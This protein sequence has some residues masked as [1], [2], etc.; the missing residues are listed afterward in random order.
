MSNNTYLIRF[1]SFDVIPS[2]SGC[3][4]RTVV[5][6]DSTLNVKTSAYCD[7]GADVK[8]VKPNRTTYWSSTSMVDLW[9]YSGL[10]TPA[11]GAEVDSHEI[12]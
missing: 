4:C 8:R 5:L 2:Q 10:W 12:S 6:Y 7:M 11:S 3:Y 9:W 1:H